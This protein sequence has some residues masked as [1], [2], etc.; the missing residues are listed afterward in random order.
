MKNN[1]DVLGHGRCGR[2]EGKQRVRA[3]WVGR[4]LEGMS[5]AAELPV[6]SGNKAFLSMNVW[7][8]AAPT[9][10]SQ[11]SEV[12]SQQESADTELQQHTRTNF[13]KKYTYDISID[14]VVLLFSFIT[15]HMSNMLE[16]H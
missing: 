13:T 5:H 1:A 4:K 14:F 16:I 3:I 8:V 11:E 6:S 10:N 12:H 15:I 9:Q 2:M 7:S